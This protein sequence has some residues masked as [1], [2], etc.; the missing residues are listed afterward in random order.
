M[1][2]VQSFIEGPLLYITFSVFFGCLLMRTLF[3][4][5]ALFKT[6]Y[7]RQNKFKF[8]ALSFLKMGIPG[9]KIFIKRPVYIVVR[10]FFHFWMIV[11]PVFFAGHVM[12]L[13]ESILRF[14]YGS[15]GYVWSD[16]ITLLVLVIL[17]YFFLRRLLFVKVRRDSTRYDY[18]F[19]LLTALP[20]LTGYMLTHNTLDNLI[21]PLGVTNSGDLIWTA[22]I[23]C[24]ELV[25]FSAAVL[26]VRTRIQP[27]Q[28][29]ACTACVTNCPTSALLS[30]DTTGK[31]AIKYSHYQCLC[32]ATC[33]HTCPEEAIALRHEINPGLFFNISKKQQLRSEPLSECEKCGSRFIPDAQWMK[34]QE[35]IA[36]KLQTVCPSCRQ[37]GMIEL[38]K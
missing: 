3:F 11:V 19:L 33:L 37:R 1:Q 32:C 14:G 27:N 2:A 9:H 31:R 30:C 20:Y 25:L 34:I 12:L 29:T 8:I 17:L 22:H 5:Q 4:G 13:E 24:G 21:R 28:C 7:D 23:L 15:M 26:F 6:S 38:L 10:Y 36:V 16:R 18:L 35:I